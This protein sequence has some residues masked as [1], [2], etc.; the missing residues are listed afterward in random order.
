MPPFAIILPTGR[1]TRPIVPVRFDRG[2]LDRLAYRRLPGVDRDT[3]AGPR[4][5]TSNASAPDIPRPD[6]I[7]GQRRW[8]WPAT[9]TAWADDQPLVTCP[10]CGARVLRLVNH[11]RKHKSIG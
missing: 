6:G 1:S 5:T 3:S 2:A 7:D 11:Q 8:W 10:G 4:R 9:I